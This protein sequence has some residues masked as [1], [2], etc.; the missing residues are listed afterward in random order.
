MEITTKELYQFKQCPLKFKFNTIHRVEELNEEEGLEAAMQSTINYFYYQIQDGYLMSMDELKRKFS[1]I[2]YKSTN[3]YDITINSKQAM[4][5]QEIKAIA[6]L[7]NLHREQ[8]L[9]PDTVVSMNLDF[10]VPV[11]KDPLLFIK[12]NIPIIRSTPAGDE[13]INYKYSNSKYNLFRMRTDMNITLQAMAYQSMF[14]K[15]VYSICVHNLKTNEKSYTHR[16]RE[17]FQ[18]LYKSVK[19]LTTTMSQDLYYPRESFMCDTCTSKKY[20]IEWK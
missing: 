15:E 12:G 14:K 18:R 16:K 19:G 3:I 20:C 10:R 17:D 7:Q 4:R 1:S 11:S 13:I 9:N 8:Q 2:W 5:K 6:M